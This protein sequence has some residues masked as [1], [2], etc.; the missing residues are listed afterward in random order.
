MKEIKITRRL[1]DEYRE[2]RKRHTIPILEL[3]LEEMKH[4]DNGIGNSTINDYRTG[5]ARPQSVVGFDWE[6]YEKRKKVLK[7]KKAK[8][9]AVERWIE[10]I[11]DGQTRYVFKSFYRDTMD[12]GKIAVKMGYA[13]SPEYPRLVIRDKY[14]KN[15]GIM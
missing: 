2:M 14:L 5:Q 11:E 6:L 15:C 3:E 1:L 4:G 12:W 10:N 9:R 8:A 7:E 13:N